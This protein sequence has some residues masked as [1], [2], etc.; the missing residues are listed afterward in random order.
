MKR[1]RSEKIQRR[2]AVTDEPML[3]DPRLIGKPLA[4]P[5]RRAAAFI[6][7]GA[8]V[9]LALFLLAVAVNN[10]RYPNLLKGGIEYYRAEPGPERDAVGRRLT[11]DVFRIIDERNPRVLPSDVRS[12]IQTHADSVLST[13]V[14]SDRMSVALNLDAKESKFNEETGL[15]SLGSDVVTGFGGFASGAVVFMAYFTILTWAMR[16]KTPGKAL[17]GIR[18][19]ALNGRNMS[20]WGS[21]GRAGGYAASAATGFLGFLEVFWDPNRQTIHDRIAGTVVIRE[22]GRR[23]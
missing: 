3:V 16:G 18:A 5:F 21:F 7:D 14:S 19:T 10:A 2:R 23:G 12:A 13:L 9:V 6:V 20:L 11:A 17:A 1:S 15:L 22:Q 8:L 4:S